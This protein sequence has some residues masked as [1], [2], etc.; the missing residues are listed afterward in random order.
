VNY[1][2]VLEYIDAYWDKLIRSTPQDEGTLIGLPKPY[3]VPSENAIFREMFY[4]DSYFTTLGLLETSHEHLVVDIVE[5]MAYLYHR[6]GVIPNGTR[7]YFLS[8]SQ[9]PFFTRLL[10]F[11]FEVKR[12]RGDPDALKWLEHKLRIARQEHETVW[13]GTEHPHHRLVHQG[14]SRYFDI[15]YLDILASCESGWDHSTRCDERWLEHV[16]V[17]LNAIL[18]IREVDIAEMHD[19]L[20]EP[21]RARMWNLRALVRGQTMNELMWDEAQGFYFDFDF[22]AERRNPHPSLAGFYPLWAGLASPEQAQRVV[23]EWLPRFEREGGLLTTLETKAGRQWAAPNGWA[24]LHWIVV[25]GLERYGFHAD[26]RRVMRSWC[27][28]NAFVFE[29][30]GAMWEKYNVT[31]VGSEGEGGLYGSLKGFGWTNGVFKDFATR[32]ARDDE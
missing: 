7:Y 23:L 27:D 22:K 16:P 5:N 19:I 1:Q 26:A 21:E 2:P 20:R 6:F 9:P 3:L 32:L 18:Y 25:A 24:P 8:R 12:R 11:A 4:W 13:L 31:H 15:N 10:K 14:L 29:R 28:N 17:D 30:T